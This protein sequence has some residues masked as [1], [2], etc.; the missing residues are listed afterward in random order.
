MRSFRSCCP[1]CLPDDEQAEP[2]AHTPQSSWSGQTEEGLALALPT[3]PPP[4]PPP[5]FDT[6]AEIQDLR[7]RLAERDFNIRELVQVR[8]E[9]KRL[10]VEI[11]R[12]GQQLAAGNPSRVMT[13][14]EPFKALLDGQAAA[15]EAETGKY[16]EGAGF[17]DFFQFGDTS[18]FLHGLAGMTGEGLQRS[19]EEE[20]RDNEDGKWWAEYEYVVK[21]AAEE[22]A[23]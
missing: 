12:L 13:A 14:W 15:R 22:D 16:G 5:A 2:L 1:G 8:E 3:V 9:N 10:R 19:M 20:C 23:C 21:R 18:E 6:A 7:D 4:S 11:E 17:V